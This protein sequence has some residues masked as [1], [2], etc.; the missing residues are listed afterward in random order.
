MSEIKPV[1][2]RVIVSVNLNFKNSHT[3]QDGTKIT[4]ERDNGNLNRREVSPVNG[5]VISAEHIPTDAE[6]LISHN[7]CHGVN[8][9]FN[10][11]QLSGEFQAGEV[12]YFSLPETDCF[13]YRPKWETEWIPCKG[14]ATALRIF[15]PY[16]GF[17]QGIPPTLIPNKLYITSGE[18]KGQVAC[19]L[20]ASDY[21][22]VFQESNGRENRKIRL[23]HFEDEKE[24]DREEITAIDH[25]LTREINEGNYLIGLSTSDAKQLNEAVCQN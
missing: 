15:R 8:E 20:K 19:V 21:E 9:L 16:T 18:Y 12:R 1:H 14:F 3:F 11:T 2:G 24:G 6:V 4:L 5:V 7:S 13:L 25:H 23:R 22:V 17:I 10:Y